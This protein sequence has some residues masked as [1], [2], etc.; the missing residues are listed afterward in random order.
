MT[1]SF[2]YFKL[3]LYCIFPIAILFTFWSCTA[4]PKS[5]SKI[6]ELLLGEWKFSPENL[7]AFNDSLTLNSSSPYYSEMIQAYQGSYFKINADKTYELLLGPE[8]QAGQ[9]VIAGKNLHL[10]PFG[11]A[12]ETTEL[13]ELNE[14]RML[15]RYFQENKD[16]I[17]LIFNR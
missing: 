10:T 7:T 4:V 6:Q 11:N 1:H 14:D 3:R 8:S 17:S 12:A 16:T 13:L 2:S 15:I 9:W 5:E